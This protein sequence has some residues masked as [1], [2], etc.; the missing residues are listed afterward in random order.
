[1]GFSLAYA[2]SLV[3]FMP[4]VLTKINFFYV[5]VIMNYSTKQAVE[6]GLLAQGGK[7]DI[8]RVDSGILSP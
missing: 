4:H 7:D 2:T 8:K 1:M 5:T 3:A 6:R